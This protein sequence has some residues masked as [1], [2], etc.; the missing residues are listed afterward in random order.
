MTEELSLWWRGESDQSLPKLLAWATAHRLLPLLAWRA[1]QQGWSLPTP[2]ARAAQQARYQN[3]AQQALALRQLEGL[4]QLA[5]RLDI[6]IVL[7]KGPVVAKTYPSPWMR[8]YKDID[9]LVAPSDAS[10]LAAALRA[11]GYQMKVSGMRGFHLPPLSP[12]SPGLRIEI[13]TLL[14]QDVDDFTIARWRAG[15]QNWDLL[16][17]IQAP[18]PVDHFLY[19][20]AHLMKHRL[21]IGLL[22]LADLKFWTADWAESEWQTLSA[23]AEAA[24]MIH[25]VGLALSLAAWFWDEAWPSEVSMLFPSPPPD[26]MTTAQRI[27]CGELVQRMPSVWRDLPGRDVRGVLSYARVVLFGDSPARQQLQGWERVAFFLRRPF[28]LLKHHGPALWRLLTREPATQ[29]AWTAQRQLYDWLTE[30]QVS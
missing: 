21:N 28:S 6:P 1:T 23:R 9:I 29:S 30:H 26:V 8:A 10:P 4:G 17:G 15:L 7:V 24:R 12:E 22:S 2:L 14:I 13:H 20:V 3:Q 5:Q 11:Q 16:P 18:H 25:V 19:L 27:I